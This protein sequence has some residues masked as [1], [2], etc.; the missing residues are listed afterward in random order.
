MAAGRP[1]PAERGLASRFEQETPMSRTSSHPIAAAALSSAVAFTGASA[2]AAPLDPPTR[3]FVEGLPKGPPIYTLA[4]GAARNVLSSVQTSVKVALPAVDVQDHTLAVGPTGHTKVRVLRPVGAKGALPVIVYVHGGGWVLG[5][6][7]THDRLA[8]ELTAG[9]GAVMVFVDY[10]RS[11]EARFPVAIEQ[12]YAVLRHVAEHPGEFSADPTR[13][14]IAGDSVGG[15]MAAVVALMA[16]E[17]SGPKLT[18]QLLF[19]PVT[20]ASMSTGSYAEF[21]EGPWL[22]AKAMAWYWDQYMPEARFRSD[23]HASPLN[24]TPDDL[25]GLPR[26]LLIVDENDVLRDEGEAYGRKLAEAGVPVT[27][28]R[29]NGTVH[30]FMMLN[31]LAET[32]A[33][34]AA[35]GQAIGYLRAVFVAR[36]EDA[37]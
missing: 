24:A 36:P 13:M 17:R 35:V 10:D 1:I 2:A 27:S 33:V 32:P 20:D 11:P 26:T 14:V 28:L 31:P 22:T 29:Y 18:A 4:P 34:R 8:R 3:A 15:N 16:K 30:D 25:R 12:A 19:Y 6:T 37:R 5:D 7:Q 9:S 21:A 23:I